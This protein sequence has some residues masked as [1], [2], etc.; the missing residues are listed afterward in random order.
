[1]AVAPERGGSKRCCG[2]GCADGFAESASTRGEGGRRLPRRVVNLSAALRRRR[3]RYYFLL[4]SP[5]PPPPLLLLALLLVPACLCTLWS[6]SSLSSP[7]FRYPPLRGGACC[8]SPSS[9]FRSAR[10]D[11]LLRRYPPCFDPSSY[12]SSFVRSLAV[13]HGFRGRE[14]SPSTIAHACTLV[15]SFSLFPFLPLRIGKQSARCLLSS[16]STCLLTQASCPRS[17]SLLSYARNSRNDRSR[18]SLLD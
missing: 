8:S 13:S 6:S 17:I 7:F 10:L 2:R 15:P 18:K 16:H 3:G 14:I 11:T 12:P 5:L 4:S 1:M 9:S